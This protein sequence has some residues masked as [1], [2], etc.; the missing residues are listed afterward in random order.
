MVAHRPEKGSNSQ[1]RYKYRYLYYIF[2][3]RYC[4]IYGD[5]WYINV[6]RNQRCSNAA[7]YS[8]LWMIN[9]FV[10]LIFLIAFF[11]RARMALSL[12]YHQHHKKIRPLNILAM[13]KR[14]AIG[15]LK[16][17]KIQTNNNGNANMWN[18][19]NSLH[20]NQV[21]CLTFSTANHIYTIEFILWKLPQNSVK[22]QEKYT[23]LYA[24]IWRKIKFKFGLNVIL[25]FVFFCFS[26]N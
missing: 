10:A 21:S 15:I 20:S 12:L 11:H 4:E 23:Y 2:I 18:N 6:A 1:Y 25:T 26:S 24:H 13:R 9:V 3:Q 22:S 7:G 14:K 8:S 19:T 17:W 5:M 16:N